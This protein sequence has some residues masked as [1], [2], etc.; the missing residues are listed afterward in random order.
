MYSFCD[1][2]RTTARLLDGNTVVLYGDSGNVLKYKIFNKSTGLGEG[3]TIATL[4]NYIAGSNVLAHPTEDKFA[5]AYIDNSKNVHL[6]EFTKISGTNYSIKDQQLN[7]IQGL[8][9]DSAGQMD[10]GYSKADAAWIVSFGAHMESGNQYYYYSQLFKVSVGDLANNTNRIIDSAS[11]ISGFYPDCYASAIIPKAN[12]GFVVFL[13]KKII[14]GIVV[15]DFDS[16]NSEPSAKILSGKWEKYGNPNLKAGG[17]SD[18]KYYYLNSYADKTGLYE[19]DFKSKGVVKL[20][21]WV[22][23]DQF[24]NIIAVDENSDPYIISSTNDGKLKVRGALEDEGKMRDLGVAGL[25]SS[26][27]YLGGGTQIKGRE[28]SLTSY[29]HESSKELNLLNI[30]DLET[31]ALNKVPG[32]PALYFQ[33]ELVSE[34][35]NMPTKVKGNGFDTITLS[36]FSDPENDG[37]L[38]KM[39]RLTN[40]VTDVTEEWSTDNV[41]FNNEVSAIKYDGQH[42]YFIDRSTANF[43]VSRIKP[44]GTGYE[45]FDKTYTN[46]SLFEVDETSIYFA[47]QLDNNYLYKVNKD[48]TGL[49][50]LAESEPLYLKVQD[51]YVFFDD[52]NNGHKMARVNKDGSD[53]RTLLS[54]GA[55]E[56]IQTNSNYVYYK[57]SDVYKIYR[58]SHD[59]TNKTDLM[60]GISAASCLL[61]KDY[62]YYTDSITRRVGRVNLS[63]LAVEQN[64]NENV[65]MELAV[66]DN[67]MYIKNSSQHIYKYNLDGTSP[68]QLNQDKS[69]DICSVGNQI[70][71]MSGNKMKTLNKDETVITN[72]SNDFQTSSMR[73]GDVYKLEVGWKDVNGR[74]GYSEPRYITTQLITAGTVGDRSK[75][76]ELSTASYVSTTK[77]TE[78]KGL[79]V[80]QKASGTKGKAVV[81]ETDGTTTTYGPLF[82]VPAVDRLYDNSVMRISDNTVLLAFSDCDELYANG[83]VYVG[84]ITGTNISWGSNIDLGP[85]LNYLKPVLLSPTKAIIAYRH[86]YGGKGKVRIVDIS[87]SYIGTYGNEKIFS[88]GA[89]QIDMNA[90]DETHFLLLYNGGSNQVKAIVGEIEGANITFGSEISLDND[91]VWN[92]LAKVGENKYMATYSMNKENELRTQLLSVDPAR[93]SVNTIGNPLTFANTRT[94]HIK[95]IQKDTN[96]VLVLYKNYDNEGEVMELQVDGANI[97]PVGRSIFSETFS[98]NQIGIEKMTDEFFTVIYSTG[99]AG[100]TVTL[101]NNKKPTNP[102][103]TNYD[104]TLSIDSLSPTNIAVSPKETFVLSTFSDGDIGDTQAKIHWKVTK[105]EDNSI[106]V[107][108]KATTVEAFIDLDTSGWQVDTLYKLEVG[109]EDNNGAIGWSTPR[110]IMPL[111]PPTITTATVQSKDLEFEFIIEATDALHGLSS[112]PVRII[113][114]N[115]SGIIVDSGWISIESDNSYTLSGMTPNQSYSLL[116]EVKNNKGVISKQAIDQVTAATL[117]KLNLESV[118]DSSVEITVIDDNPL[119]TEYMFYINN[120][121]VN[122][123]GIVSEEGDWIG[124]TDDFKFKFNTLKMATDYILRAT[125]RNNSVAPL[126]TSLSS[127]VYTTTTGGPPST[128]PT[129]V[130]VV[131][132]QTFVNVFYDD[133]DD[134]SEY[135]VQLTKHDGD[136]LTEQSKTS[137]ELMVKFDNLTPDTAYDVTVNS[138]NSAGSGPVSQTYQFRTLMAL[139]EAPTFYNEKSLVLNDLIKLEWDVISNAHGYEIFVD[140]RII[141]LGKK[142]TFTHENLSSNMLHTYKVRA[143]NKSGKSPWSGLKVIS[144]TNGLPSEIAEISTSTTD[145]EIIINWN[146]TDNAHAYEIVLGN[147]VFSDIKDSVI[148]LDGLSSSAKYSFII[149]AYNQYGESVSS[150]LVDITTKSTSTPQGFKA[151]E[152]DQGVKLSWNAVSGET[153]YLVKVSW[154]D[155]GNPQETLHQVTGNVF[156]HS[157]LMVEERKNY[158]VCVYKDGKEA[159]AYTEV[160]TASKLPTQIPAPL[161]IIALATKNMIKLTWDTIANS[162]VK[163]YEIEVDDVVMDN[164]SSTAYFHDDLD[165]LTNHNY[166]IRGVSESIE[167]I[168]SGIFQVKT[169]SGVPEKPE[170]ISIH[171]TK[172]IAEINWDVQEEAYY[173]L[174][175]IGSN[176]TE[177]TIDLGTKNSYKHRRINDGVEYKYQLQAYNNVGTS[178]WSGE[179]VNNHLLARCKK[180]EAI[181]LGLTASDIADFDNYVLKVTYTE[182]AL[183]IEDLSGYTSEKELE[184]G[185]IEGTDIEITD[186]REGQITFKVNKAINDGYTW[187]GVIN[188]IK[189]VPLLSGG[190]HIS[191]VVEKRE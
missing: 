186:L 40:T 107:G 159:S 152:S 134:A 79:I 174:K 16:W 39:A 96:S 19:Y 148:K 71:F 70:V 64:L 67:N 162:E 124:K 142:N 20:N 23:A 47:N 151:K 26:K 113:A 33:N 117:P 110:Y 27:F 57:Q 72:P 128:P 29:F 38:G 179:I 18:S 119:D 106:I 122:Q 7:G 178:S 154:I 55:V 25:S 181:D 51:N 131:S 144:T 62:L 92:S 165:Y 133:M 24:D 31:I 126:E 184:V 36:P 143:V 168:W 48:G 52:S 80:F 130:R 82:D 68:V 118:M 41:I 155:A 103:V 97:I 15:Y 161:N 45:V 123:Q 49:L 53:L 91:A 146:T 3:V 9:I 17:Y 120:K 182:G 132:S 21:E 84:T 169:L 5:V 175:I 127:G 180:G 88:Y 14:S 190:T 102:E 141:N 176:D 58:T 34:D 56:N 12:G 60:P 147:R 157:E 95:A 86:S 2:A 137:S 11:M 85:Q 89:N 156:E 99:R 74:I 6:A 44:D 69:V 28:I 187:T 138:V 8:N 191:Y 188:N 61:Y 114:D 136:S 73:K 149:K 189:F 108:E 66:D 30:T 90:I 167:G 77:L 46:G 37:K 81:Y 158:Q 172:Y 100:E 121:P 116:I 54:S 65:A 135:N 115:N 166:R 42:I 140:G 112:L 170:N 125:A 83:N 13:E 78:T 93:N 160:L 111:N 185:M 10:I 76:Y 171:S 43:H 4:Q 22:T 98:Y 1:G 35:K 163:G 183:K 105:E 177:S 50:K 129:N 145:S 87:G 109:Y 164:E 94:S 101:W 75:F 153:D 150:Q 63:T 32:Q 173:R 104:Q 59:G 139:P